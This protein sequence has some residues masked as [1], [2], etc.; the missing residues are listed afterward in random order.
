MLSQYLWPIRR[1]R[2][3]LVLI[4]L[5]PAILLLL[6]ITVKWAIA[7]LVYSI[8]LETNLQLVYSSAARV[9]TKA[10]KVY[11]IALIRESSRYLRKMRG[12][13]TNSVYLCVANV[14]VKW[15]GFEI[16]RILMMRNNHVNSIARFT[17]YEYSNLELTFSALFRGSASTSQRA[18]D[19]VRPSSRVAQNRSMKYSVWS[20]A[21]DNSG[22]ASSRPTNS[23]S[24]T[25]HDNR[26]IEYSILQVQLS[27]C[28]CS[29]S[30]CII[31]NI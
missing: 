13:I 31:F 9:V 11:H 22:N 2:S 12:L 8:C 23:C 20:L 18:D 26:D 3:S 30:R 19:R 28:M 29:C 10:P 6:S 16:F 1:V 27:I 17:S 25:V 5:V 15:N 24:S 21:Q 14:D 7:T 4:K